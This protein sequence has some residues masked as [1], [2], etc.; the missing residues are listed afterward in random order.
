[1]EWIPVIWALLIVLSV[2]V[3]AS[4]MGLVAVWFMPG[5]LVAL[6]LSFFHV[7]LAW[8][9]VAFVGVSVLMTVLGLRWVR[10]K[11]RKKAY[12]TNAMSLIGQEAL[13]VEKVDRLAG[14]GAARISGMVWTVR[15]ADEAEEINVGDVVMVEAI[16]GNKLICRK[17]TAGSQK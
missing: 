8:Q 13:V 17:V 12:A 5:A 6:I 9:V 14:T 4:T 11:M 16:Q 10:P 7:N 2:V 1:M 3:E 15:A